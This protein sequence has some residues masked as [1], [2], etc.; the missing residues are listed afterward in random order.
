MNYKIIQDEQKLKNFI[1]FLPELQLNEQYYVALF[2]RKKYDTTGT[3]KSDKGQLKRFTSTKEHLFQ[4]IKQLEVEIGAYQIDGNSVP[5]ETLALYIS[6]NPRDLKKAAIQSTKKLLDLVV[7]DNFNA[8]PHQTVLSEIQK[9]CGKKHFMDFDFDNSSWPDFID[10]NREFWDDNYFAINILQTRGGFHLLI[11]ID[12]IN[13][14][15]KNFWYQYLSKLPNVD[16]KGDNL[17]PVPGCVQGGTVP[18]FID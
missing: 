18:A 14:K 1:K 4:K 9:S 6:I 15:W 11:E 12:K 8:N 5:E 16:I 7:S 2:C 10:N 13:D 3:I 17:I